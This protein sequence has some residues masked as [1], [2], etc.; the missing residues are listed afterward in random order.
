MRIL[1][2]VLSIMLLASCE[3]PV[4]TPKPRAYPKVT[5][6]EKAYQAFN[7]S[8][9]GFSF[10]YPKYA[11]IQKDTTFFDKKPAHPCWFNIL[12]K[13]FDCRIHC[14][15]APISKQTPADKLKTDAFKM[16]DWHNKKA[17]YIEE[18]PLFNGAH[19]V[20]GMLFTVEGPV[21]SQLQFFLTDTAEQQHFFRG[22][23][24]FYT[25]ANP[26]S[27]APVYDFMRKDVERMIE[28][29]QWN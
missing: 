13:G 4:L 19:N 25:Q 15:Y 28:T 12:V 3:E 18:A 21:A 20:K 26:D 23:L 29:F 24:Y 8:Y 1:V 9:C 17:T 5:H 7:E 16:T 2:F 14:S 27:L 22:A 6:P 10:E 11:V